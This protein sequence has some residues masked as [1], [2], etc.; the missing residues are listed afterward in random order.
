MPAHLIAHAET[1]ASIMRCFPVVAQLRPHLDGPE[2]LRR[3]EVQR[4]GGYQLAFLEADERI[5]AVAGYRFG[6]ALAWGRFC[7]V[8]DLVTDERDRSLGF[9]RALFAWLIERAREAGCAQFHLDS[10][11]QRFAAHRFYLGQRME[12]SSH[13]FSLSLVATGTT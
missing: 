1:A 4:A 7:Y 6:N 13:H 9:G 12:I 11:V 5:R 8:D 3:V 2:F 10:G